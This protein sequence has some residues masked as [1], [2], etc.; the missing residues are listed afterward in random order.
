MEA[1]GK[2]REKRVLEDGM[3]EG[4]KT[5]ADAQIVYQKTSAVRM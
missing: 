3:E 2:E 1:H 5:P 4:G